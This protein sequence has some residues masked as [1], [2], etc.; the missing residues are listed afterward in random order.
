MLTHK[1]PYIPFYLVAFAICNT[2]NFLHGKSKCKFTYNYLH[3][4]L[5]LTTLRGSG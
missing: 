3:A 4:F 5:Y 2:V 1:Y